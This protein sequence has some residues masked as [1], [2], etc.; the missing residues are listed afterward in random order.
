MENMENKNKPKPTLYSKFIGFMMD[1]LNTRN[2]RAA[3]S[4]KISHSKNKKE[5]EK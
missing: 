3:L 1:L 5:C 4:K 2:Y